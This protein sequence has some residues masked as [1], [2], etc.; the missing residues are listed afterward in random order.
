[1]NL[2]MLVK[3]MVM[4]YNCHSKKDSIDTIDINDMKEFVE[5]IV[6]KILK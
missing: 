4:L 3:D 6:M 1:M 5:E 2:F